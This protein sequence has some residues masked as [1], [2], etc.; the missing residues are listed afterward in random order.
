MK[1]GHGNALFI[2]DTTDKRLSDDEIR[3]RWKRGDYGKIRPDYA[4]GWW[5]MAG[6]K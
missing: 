3:N 5:N 1:P 4:K 6:R 2:A